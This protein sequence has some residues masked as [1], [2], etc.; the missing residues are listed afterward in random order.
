MQK[1]GIEELPA[2]QAY[3]E[4]WG[5][6]VFRDSFPAELSRTFW[7]KVDQAIAAN[8]NLTYSLFGTL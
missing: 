7:D 8:E 4:K 2:A 3:F 1:F 5:Y 6:V